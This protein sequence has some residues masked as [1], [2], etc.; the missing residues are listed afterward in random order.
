MYSARLRSESGAMTAMLAMKRMSMDRSLALGPSR[1]LERIGQGV[2]DLPVRFALDHEM[3]VEDLKGVRDHVA[4]GVA[5]VHP[6][7]PV[8]GRSDRHPRRASDQVQLVRAAP[9]PVAGATSSPARGEGPYAPPPIR[10]ELQR[11]RAPAISTCGIVSTDRR[12]VARPH[13]QRVAPQSIDTRRSPPGARATSR[14]SQTVT[15]SPML[16]R[17]STCTTSG[18][19]P[20]LPDAGRTEAA[21]GHVPWRLVTVTRKSHAAPEADPMLVSRPTHEP[22]T[23]AGSVSETL[24]APGA[25]PLT[26]RSPTLGPCSSMRSSA[27]SARRTAAIASDRLSQVSSAIGGSVDTV[28]SRV[29]SQ[30]P[31]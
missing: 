14:G 29:T 3:C 4:V 2:R 22:V 15:T 19:A 16:D 1:D 20:A 30:S 23:S 8:G 12:R 25:G 26:S 17:G 6:D 31:F 13:G 10:D 5:H 11:S 27:T 9:P 7:D 18:V 24:Q 21:T 28:T